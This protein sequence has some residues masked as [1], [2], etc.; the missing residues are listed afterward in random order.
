MTIRSRLAVGFSILAL[1]AGF[2][3]ASAAF[4]QTMNKDQGMSK[5]MD[6]KM[7]KD[8]MSK[9]GMKKPDAMTKPDGMADK[10]KGTSDGMK[11]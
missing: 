4:G 8:E 7:K 10:K 5:P 3:F 6:D 1:S 2:G 11:K 9:D